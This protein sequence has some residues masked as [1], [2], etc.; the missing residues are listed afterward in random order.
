MSNVQEEDLET[1]RTSGAT[2]SINGMPFSLADPWGNYAVSYEEMWHTSSYAMNT[3]LA[4]R[5]LQ[6]GCCG[7]PGKHWHAGASNRPFLD[8]FHYKIATDHSAEVVLITEIQSL[9]SNTAK[10]WSLAGFWW[11]GWDSASEITKRVQ[12]EEGVAPTAWGGNYE[13]AGIRAVHRRKASMLF[14]DLHAKAHNPV[15]D[16]CPNGMNPG[17]LPNGYTAQF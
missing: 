15:V 9:K 7:I 6:E 3:D 2:V 5:S 13:P 17:S 8:E 11:H 16:I 14:F 4:R 10:I 1:L 12:W